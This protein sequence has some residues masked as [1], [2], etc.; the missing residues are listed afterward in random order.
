MNPAKTWNCSLHK[1]SW[2]TP[3]FWQSG[4]SLAAW[5]DKNKPPCSMSIVHLF[6]PLTQSEIGEVRVRLMT[7]AVV[8]RDSWQSGGG[9]VW[10]YWS[11]CG[12]LW[13]LSGGLSVIT[14]GKWEQSGVVL[15]VC[16]WQ[17]RQTV[18]SQRVQPVSLVQRNQL[19][20]V[21]LGPVSSL[22]LC[23]C[24]CTPPSISPSLHAEHF[25]TA[26]ES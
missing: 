5:G 22:F 26:Q 20:F 25:M 4:A 9:G 21:S 24:P 23:L 7:A 13:H 11:L 1:F 19:V 6:K 16:V 18:S 14:E 15:C 12:H 10:G 2:N 17:S 8:S 3:V